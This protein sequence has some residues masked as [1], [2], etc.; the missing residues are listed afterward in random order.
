MA[1]PEY[2]ADKQMWA[3]ISVQHTAVPW[4]EWECEFWGE[5]IAGGRPL[6][7]LDPFPPWN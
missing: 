1:T 2:A 4:A 3:Q 5:R 7:G 6:T